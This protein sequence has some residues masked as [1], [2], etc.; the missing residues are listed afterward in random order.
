MGTC[1]AVAAGND[2]IDA[3]SGD[4]DDAHDTVVAACSP[5]GDS[6][7]DEV[8]LRGSVAVMPIS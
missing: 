7:E 5:S 1:A 4:R 3:D 6:E 8:L 2:A